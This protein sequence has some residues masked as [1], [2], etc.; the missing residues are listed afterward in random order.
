[1]QNRDYLN[2]WVHADGKKYRMDFWKRNKGRKHEPTNPDGDTLILDLNVYRPSSI[3]EIGCGFGR[4][5]KPISYFFD[6]ITV[7]GCDV[8]EDM[9]DKVHGNLATFHWDI[10]KTKFTQQTHLA[11]VGFCRGVFM[12]FED[13]EVRDAMTNIDKM[14]RSK[15][16]VYEW[17]SVIKQMRRIDNSR[18]FIY[19]EI[20]QL[21]E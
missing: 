12:Y 18:K 21:Q 4:L 19:H 14:I 11:D 10:C 6:D 16:L 15:M 2:Q 1:M 13:D 5:L 20:E 7:M 9:L 17:A 8:S 3:L